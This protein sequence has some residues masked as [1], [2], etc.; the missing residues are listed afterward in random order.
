MAK[1]GPSRRWLRP[2]PTTLANI[3]DLALAGPWPGSPVVSRADARTAQVEVGK[4]R[5]KLWSPFLDDLHL[6]DR[7]WFKI[8]F[9]KRI[10]C[11]HVWIVWKK[12]KSASHLPSSQPKPLKLKPSRSSRLQSSAVPWWVCSRAPWCPTR[13]SPPGS[14]TSWGPRARRCGRATRRARGRWRSRRSPKS[15]ELADYGHGLC[16]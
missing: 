12:L 1:V 10:G 6:S 15:W 7:F 2:P 11:S 14:W 5:W 4:N 8:L 9:H 3:R 13:A 16:R